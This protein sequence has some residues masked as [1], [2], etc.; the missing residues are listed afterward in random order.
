MTFSA[1]N[2]LCLRKQYFIRSNIAIIL[3]ILEVPAL[4]RDPQLGYCDRFSWVFSVPAFLGECL[5]IYHYRFSP[6]P[7]KLSIWYQTYSPTL[8]KPLSSRSVGASTAIKHFILCDVFFFFA[9]F[10]AP[11]G[12]GL[13]FFSFMII[14]QKVGLLERVIS[15]SQGLYLNTGHHK[16]IHIPNIH[17]LCGIRTHDPGFRASEDSTCLRPLGYRDGPMWRILIV[18]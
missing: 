4:K 14:L 15:S 3:R 18:N 1:W 10:T 7:L 11:L 2:K 16:H 17:A 13:W 12:P 5:K 8:H 6:Y 9:G